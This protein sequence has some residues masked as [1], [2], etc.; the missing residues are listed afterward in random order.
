MKRAGLVYF[1]SHLTYSTGPA[2]PRD[3]LSAA[4][5]HC[6]TSA[7]NQVAHTRGTT[8][9]EHFHWQSSFQ[10]KGRRGPPAVH[11]LWSGRSSTRCNQSRFRPPARLRVCCHGEGLGWRESC[12]AFK[13]NSRRCLLG[14]REC[15]RGSVRRFWVWAQNSKTMLATGQLWQSK[16]GLKRPNDDF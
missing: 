4:Y 8:H 6:R 11:S 16:A 1:K 12:G 9:E 3:D 14:F 7:H 5:L 2:R 13:R 15:V 10:H